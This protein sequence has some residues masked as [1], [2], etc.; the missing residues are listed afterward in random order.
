MTTDDNFFYF[1]ITVEALNSAG[2]E[3][4]AAIFKKGYSFTHM[5]EL[6]LIPFYCFIRMP[7]FT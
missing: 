3:A 6:I 5:E 1:T 7:L 4:F 2:H